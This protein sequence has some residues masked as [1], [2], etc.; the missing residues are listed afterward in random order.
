MASGRAFLLALLPLATLRAQDLALDVR[1]LPD[2]R[3]AVAITA[4][5]FDIWIATPTSLSRW[6]RIGDAPAVW[7]GAGHDLP[8]AGLA[9]L[10]WD[11][12]SGTLR[13]QGRDGV[14]YTWSEPFQRAS[15][16]DAHLE[17]TSP[18]SRQ[19]PSSELP[20]LIPEAD[21]WMYQDG[22]LREPGGRH[23][24]IA[25]ALVVEDR[26]LWLITGN[27][28]IWKGRWPSGRVAPVA[29][30]LGETCIE[31]AVKEPDGTLW[32]LG[33]SGS[34]ARLGTD[35]SLL[36]LDPRSPRWF[37]LRDAI[38]IAP[39]RPR[40]VWVA[41]PAGV[42][43]VLAT[44]VQEV[45]TGRKAPFGGTPV[46]LVSRKDTTWCLT[47]H[48]VGRSVRS[49]PFRALSPSTDSVDAGLRILCLAP[50]RAGLLAGTATGFRLW[51]GNDWSHVPA[52]R[53]ADSRSV[54]KI[55]VQPGGDRIAWSDG[56]RVRVDTLPGGK[57]K[58]EVL[59]P[60]GTIHDIAWGDDGLVQI[61]HGAWTLWN[62]DNGL[63][64]TWTL[65]VNA[66]L[67][68]PDLP[69]SFV[70]GTTG[71]VQARTSAWAP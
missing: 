43:H 70:A 56:V 51:T 23:A 26:D 18:I 30:G 11:A 62:P 47:R 7:Y 40:G 49:G 42:V 38:D 39:A 2:A 10:C 48:G 22:G 58:P 3:G 31:R 46:S 19:I 45:Y 41:T 61:A 15:P 59:T 69:W 66:E 12:P 68:V 60:K 6:P 54:L 13:L 24:S 37:D 29:G 17:C 33:C 4:S 34:L 14:S 27:S 71:G 57:G 20:A 1:P 67:V 65:P 35:G 52:L 16:S 63:V 50:T 53:H 44:G 9:D 28:G 8:M 55:A 25:R 32:M 64:R 5:P 36:P 21:G